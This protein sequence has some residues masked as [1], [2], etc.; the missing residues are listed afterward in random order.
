MSLAFDVLNSQS[1]GGLQQ[2]RLAA[3][4]SLSPA[5]FRPGRS[6]AGSPFDKSEFGNE[7]PG[8]KSSL[9][10]RTHD[11]RRPRSVSRPAARAACHIAVCRPRG[12]RLDRL[13]GSGGILLRISVAVSRAG[14][15][16]CGSNPADALL[17]N[18]RPLPAHSSR[19]AAAAGCV[20]MPQTGPR[21]SALVN[22]GRCRLGFG[23]RT[24][25]QSVCAARGCVGGTI[26]NFGL[27]RNVGLNLHTSVPSLK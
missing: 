15:A 22:P 16:R 19:R 21:G 2:M 11:P 26:A 12:D 17:L 6:I 20:L 24:W 8:N 25:R 4:R 18:E 1:H 23:N 10:H 3:G 13:H 7:R 9:T 27:R 14:M 5:G